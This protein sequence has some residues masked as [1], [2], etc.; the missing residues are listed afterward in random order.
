MRQSWNKTLTESV[1]LSSP[2][3]SLSVLLCSLQLYSQ[4]TERT[5][6]GGTVYLS[7]QEGKHF[8]VF[9]YWGDRMQM[10]FSHSCTNTERTTSWAVIH[11]ISVLSDVFHCLK[12]ES[13]VCGG[14]ENSLNSMVTNAALRKVKADNETS[15]SSPVLKL[16][17]R[18]WVL[19]VFTALKYQRCWKKHFFCE[20]L[21][22]CGLFASGNPHPADIHLN[23]T[24]FMKV[25]SVHSV[26]SAVSEAVSATQFQQCC[27]LQ[28]SSSV[29]TERIT[30]SHIWREGERAHGEYCGEKTFSFPFSHY[31]TVSWAIEPQSHHNQTP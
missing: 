4:W 15:F 11:H 17:G 6:P 16:C 12:E 3:F 10:M 23:E 30:N 1:S 7:F 2:L 13:E 19:R 5:S 9:S 22:I 8:P 25:Y 24:L 26:K 28:H 14:L 21:I 20:N 29:Q 31:I 18:L 27:S